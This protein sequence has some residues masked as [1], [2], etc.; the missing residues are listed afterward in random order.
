[1][2]RDQR[3]ALRLKVHAKIMRE[4]AQRIGCELV[5]ASR[6]AYTQVTKMT[7]KQLQRELE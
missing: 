2:T 1:M 6:T 5:E 7:V 4:I 3:I